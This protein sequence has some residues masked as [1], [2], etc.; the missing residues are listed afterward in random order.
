MPLGNHQTSS[1][2]DIEHSLQLN[3][4]R[5]WLYMY[6]F[7]VRTAYLVI[8]KCLSYG[9]QQASS[10]PVHWAKHD[11][12]TVQRSRTLGYIPV[13]V[14]CYQVDFTATTN[15]CDVKWYVIHVHDIILVGLERTFTYKFNACVTESLVAKHDS[16]LLETLTLPLYNNTTP[17][18]WDVRGST[19]VLSMPP[20]LRTF[21]QENA[22]S[23]YNYHSII[24]ESQQQAG[25]Y[26]F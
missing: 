18:E 7:L 1:V 5:I 13:Y 14:W 23:Q 19:V 16:E 8:D 20:I 2:S 15:C 11:C 22:L 3:D 10:M 9:C 26:L 25:S 6:V 21:A 12:N 17:I 24:K 4:Q